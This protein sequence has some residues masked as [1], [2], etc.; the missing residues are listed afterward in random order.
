MRKSSSLAS[1]GRFCHA[2][3][4]SST[5]LVTREIR[6]KSVGRT[7]AVFHPGRPLSVTPKIVD[8][9]TAPAYPRLP[10]STGD[11][12]GSRCGRI[13]HP[14]RR[15]LRCMAPVPEP[16]PPAVAAG[17][18]TK[19]QIARPLFTQKIGGICGDPRRAPFAR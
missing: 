1:S 15:Q 12:P 19:P 9:S 18:A 8:P 11:H 13:H 5:A 17:I 14:Q 7:S 16:H 3:T 10:P 6:L 2:F 4:L